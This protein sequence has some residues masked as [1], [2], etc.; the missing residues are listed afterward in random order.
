MKSAS[1]S[2]LQPW[3]ISESYSSMLSSSDAALYSTNYQRGQND[4]T[5]IV[6]YS[7]KSLHVSVDTSLN[8]RC[9]RI[10]T[11]S[12]RAPVGLHLGRRGHELVPRCRSVRQGFLPRTL[13]TYVFSV[14]ALLIDR[15]GHL[16]YS[17]MP[18]IMARRRSAYI[19]VIGLFSTSLWSGISYRWRALGSCFLGSF[20][21]GIDPDQRQGSSPQGEWRGGRH[22][23]RRQVGAHA[24]RKKGV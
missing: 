16:G 15:P 14:Q 24:S 20:R 9:A 2:S 10:S 22:V 17:C 4:I 3:R 21:W 11:F 8:T 13:S 23:I 5:H 6:N 1:G 12:T 7:G 18:R 19:R